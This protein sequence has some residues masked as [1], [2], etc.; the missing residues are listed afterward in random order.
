MLKPKK[1]K[2]KANEAMQNHTSLRI[3]GLAKYFVE[4]KKDLALKQLIK[5]ANELNLSIFVI[6]NGTN[7]LINDSGIDGIVLK[8]P[9][10]IKQSFFNKKEIVVSAGF[11]LQSLVG[12]CKAKNI[13][14]FEFLTG[15]PGTIGG[16][17]AMNAGAHNNEIG[18]NIKKVFCINKITGKKIV[19][20]DCQFSYRSSV[21]SKEKNLIIY[22]AIFDIKKIGFDDDFYK[23]CLNW[24]REKQKLD[25]PNAGSIFKN[26]ANISAGAL[27]D[28]IVGKGFKIGDAAISLQHANIFV[29][30]GNASFKD[31]E[32]LI[33]YVK[34]E[35]YQKEKINLEE[36]LVI[37]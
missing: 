29:N 27:I 13:N 11:Q 24:R 26:P 17:I 4:L 18:K 5:T 10:Y 15:I 32:N 9:S 19:I 28:K 36:E 33:Q 3:G 12:Y 1:I 8:L 2:L 21:F 16:A 25:L 6:G 7:L 14:G 20:K 30:L 37:I 34:Q 35:V 23:Y 31:F 22:K